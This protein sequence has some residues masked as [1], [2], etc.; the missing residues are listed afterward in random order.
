[1]PT[2]HFAGDSRTNL[3]RMLAGDLY[4]A[5]DP[6]IA[7]RQQQAVRLAARYQAA[8]AEDAEAAR[9]LLAEL[10]GSLGA[11]AH[12]RPPLYVDYGSNIS[13]GARTFVNYNLTALDVAAITIGEDCQ[14]GP[15]VQLLTPT[16]P[17]EP[18]PRRDKL[19]A[20]RPIV[21]GD[22]VW[23]GGGAI[24]L[25]GVTVGD[26]AVIGA[27]AVVTKD[28]PANVVAVGNPARPVRNV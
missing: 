18:G 7:R 21:I 24:V 26:N 28:V 9:P 20:A 23:L 27:G 5:D 19:E 11:E 10:L 2:D 15:N 12:V 6:E 22:N 16:H 1:M 13:I 3:E 25:P 14:I 8:Y 4:I 17:L